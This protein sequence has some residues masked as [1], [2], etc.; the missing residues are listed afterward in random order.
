MIAKWEKGE[1]NIPVLADKAI[2]DLYMESIGESH[3]ADIL[4]KLKDLDNQ[5]HELE[6]QF[7]ETEDGW[8]L[9]QCA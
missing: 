6:F 5:I 1:N 3:I 7:S 9:D 4:T 8:K 2:R